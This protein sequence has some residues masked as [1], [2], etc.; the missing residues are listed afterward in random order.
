MSSTRKASR[1]HRPASNWPGGD[2]AAA[3][4]AAV[5]LGAAA[6][7]A[8]VAAVAAGQLD[9]AA[10]AKAGTRSD[11]VKRN[12]LLWPGHALTRLF[13]FSYDSG[14]S[15]GPQRRQ[16]LACKLD[17]GGNTIREHLP[18]YGDPYWRQ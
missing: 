8:A 6:A 2:A 7:D 4:D 1:S 9:V 17:H 14:R 10:P 5:A 12:E 16:A 3:A 11:H 18:H 13:C 15:S